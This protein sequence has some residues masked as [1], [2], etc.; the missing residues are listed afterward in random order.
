[1]SSSKSLTRRTSSNFPCK[2][3]IPRLP[4]SPAQCRQLLLVG[5]K[6]NCNTMKPFGF[7]KSERLCSKKSIDSIFAQGQSV[8]SYPIKATFT[9][10]ALPHNEPAAQ[11]LFVVPKKKFK[12]AVHRNAIRRRV[13]ESFRLNKHTLYQWCSDNQLQVK[14]AFV[15][16]ASEKLPFEQI[17]LAIVKLIN[18]IKDWHSNISE[19]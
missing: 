15:Y 19:V 11:T 17:Q 5:N 10:E 7:P 6:I 3:E 8:F 1:M 14:I 16:V 2:G 13:R 12:R 9:I 18:S 4:K